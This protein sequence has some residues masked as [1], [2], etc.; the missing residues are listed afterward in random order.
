MFIELWKDG[1]YRLE[2]DETAF[3]LSP[4][5]FRKL[6]EV[7]KAFELAEDGAYEQVGFE[8]PEGDEDDGE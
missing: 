4:E 7:L 3:D 6:I 1:T 2:V 8:L 5:S